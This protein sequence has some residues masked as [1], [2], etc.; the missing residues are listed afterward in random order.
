[1]DD[2]GVEVRQQHGRAQH[3]GPRWIDPCASACAPS[4]IRRH[5]IRAG[6]PGPAARSSVPRRA[7]PSA[8]WAGLAL[9]KH[10]RMQ[11]RLGRFGESKLAGDE[12]R[13]SLAWGLA[14]RADQI[15][16]RDPRWQN[17]GPIASKPHDFRCL[18]LPSEFLPGQQWPYNLRR[19]LEIFIEQVSGQYGAPLCPCCV[20]MLPPCSKEATRETSGGGRSVR[21]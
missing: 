16:G 9:L 20:L 18:K 3:A 10:R 17:P 6:R 19:S 5:S 1:M 13:T 8:I 7:T 12:E 14:A 15:W 4:C 11:C 2:H 21:G